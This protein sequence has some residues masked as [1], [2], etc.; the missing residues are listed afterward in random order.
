MNTLF[1]INVLLS[2]S[3]IAVF[4]VVSSW[5]VR[6]RDVRTHRF[7]PFESLWPRRVRSPPPLTGTCECNQY[8]LRMHS[9]AAGLHV[10][11]ISSHLPPLLQDFTLKA[12]SKY[13]LDRMYTSDRFPFLSLARVFTVSIDLFDGFGLFSRCAPAS[14][15]SLKRISA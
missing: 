10:H 4:A 1:C 6:I 11:A 12:D 2:S 9:R 15:A 8:G 7:T 14:K 3:R 5:T 13:D